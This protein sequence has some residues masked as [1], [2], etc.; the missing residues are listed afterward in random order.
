MPLF[1]CSEEFC[2]ALDNTSGTCTNYWERWRR[3]QPLLC[4]S[5]DPEIGKWHGQFEKQTVKEAN[6]RK[7]KDGFFIPKR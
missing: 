5:C 2:K 4:S 1:E 3:Q 7:G 6:H